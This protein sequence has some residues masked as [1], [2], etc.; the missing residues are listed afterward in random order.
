M[1][2]PNWKL[3]LLS[4]WCTYGSPHAR[5]HHLY[6]SLL[7]LCRVP[8]NDVVQWIS[9]PPTCGTE[10]QGSC[11]K[12]IAH[13]APRGN[14]GRSPGAHLRVEER[15]VCNTPQKKKNRDRV[16][17][18]WPWFGLVVFLQ[19]RWVCLLRCVL[20]VCQRPSVKAI[21]FLKWTLSTRISSFMFSFTSLPFLTSWRRAS[22]FE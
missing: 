3:T 13:R 6:L 8:L 10:S 21:R 2:G 11:S 15:V 4:G 1:L 5:H 16:D 22:Q 12:R 19:G 17:D 18:P 20:L 14:Q 7:Q 9:Q